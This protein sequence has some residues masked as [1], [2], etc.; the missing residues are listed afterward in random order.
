MSIHT[1]IYIYIYM[2]ISVTLSLSMYIYIYSSSDIRISSYTL[3]LMCAYHSDRLKG[4]PLLPF[5]CRLPGHHSEMHIVFHGL[6]SSWQSN[7]PSCGVAVGVML[8]L[9]VSRMKSYICCTC[10][11][12]LEQM[13]TCTSLS[14]VVLIVTYA[15]VHADSLQHESFLLALC[16]LFLS[17]LDS[18]YTCSCRPYRT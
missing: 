17:D 5:A 9:V 1:Y 11:D 2:Y 16:L 14:V 18:A 8:D 15:M 3:E 13:I 4:S 10:L 6:F 12:F 7:I